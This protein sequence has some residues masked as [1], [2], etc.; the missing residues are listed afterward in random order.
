[1]DLWIGMDSNKIKKRHSSLRVSF[2]KL[3]YFSNYC[4]KASLAFDGVSY[5]TF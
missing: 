1:M 2:F 4:N 5:F 3:H